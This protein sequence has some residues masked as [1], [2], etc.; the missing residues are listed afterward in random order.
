MFAPLDAPWREHVGR[1]A[2]EVDAGRVAIPEG[3]GLGIG[4]DDAELLKHPFVPRDLNLFEDES[5]LNREI[6]LVE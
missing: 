5:I 2:I 4:L 3:P 6:D 1:P